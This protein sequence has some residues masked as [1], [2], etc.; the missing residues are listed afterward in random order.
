MKNIIVVLIILIGVSSIASSQTTKYVAVGDEAIID[1]IKYSQPVKHS[2]QSCAD[3]EHYRLYDTCFW[4]MSIENVIKP[5][6]YDTE[7]FNFYVIYVYPTKGGIFE[8]TIV[9]NYSTL[10]YPT[11]NCAF[12]LIENK[13]TPPGSTK[14]KESIVAYYDDKIKFNYVP[15]H[16]SYDSQTQSYKNGILTLEIFNNKKDSA[17]FT[18]WKILK[19]SSQSVTL[20]SLQKDSVLNDHT[21]LSGYEHNTNIQLNFRTSLLPAFTWRYFDGIIQ[22]HAH[23]GD[24]DS[25]CILPIT[26]IFEPMPKSGVSISSINANYLGI[27]PNPSS[28][29]T[30]LYLNLVKPS[31]LHL[32][33]FDKLGKDIMTIYDDKAAEGTHDF[34]LKISSGIYYAR[35]ETQDGVLTKKIVV[36]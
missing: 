19:D 30:H 11:E 17:N 23:F 29:R 12:H 22:T 31:Y 35:M 32:H 28:T 21:S 33:I 9:Q 6:S 10:F 36:E 5:F 1:S 20:M 13:C 24:K 25:L 16:F 2:F 34:S 18:D 7:N 26:F 27:Y 14:T 3:R 8:D 15:K 4:A